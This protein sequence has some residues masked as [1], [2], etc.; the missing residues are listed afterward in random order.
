[1]A[2]WRICFE[3]RVAEEV[4]TRNMEELPIINNMYNVGQTYFE[5]CDTLVANDDV[6]EVYEGP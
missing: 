6:C 4:N 1:M 5:A 3:L 2:K